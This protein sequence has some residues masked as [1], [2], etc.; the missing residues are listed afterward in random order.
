MPVMMMMM[1]MMALALSA[2]VK[3]PGTQV[4]T[5]KEQEPEESES[6]QGMRGKENVNA[7]GTM[8]WVVLASLAW[9]IIE[10]KRSS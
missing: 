1:M 5:R 9:Q 8:R 4:C 10:C 2:H 6:F 7:E 3:V